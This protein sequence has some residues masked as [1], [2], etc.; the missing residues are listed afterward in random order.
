M[1]KDSTLTANERVITTGT[2][3]TSIRKVPGTNTGSGQTQL[4]LEALYNP[5]SPDHFPPNVFIADNPCTQNLVARRILQTPTV[6]LT[7]Y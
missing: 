1:L 2:W 4:N 6:F 7:L 5:S 3:L